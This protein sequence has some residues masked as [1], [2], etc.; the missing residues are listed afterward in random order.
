MIELRERKEEE[1]GMNILVVEDD[2][3]IREGIVEF[4]S[5]EGYQVLEAADGEEGLAMFQKN[6]VHLILLDIMLPKMDGIQVLQEIRRFSKIPVLMLTAMTDE[7]TQVK[8][9]DELADDYMCKPFSLILLKK[10]VEALLRRNY[11]ESKIFTYGDA[12]VDFTGFTATYQGEDAL[13]KPKEIKLLEVLTA[14]KGQVMTREQ[15]LNSIWGE[16]EAPFD[17][18]IDVYVKN[19]R[20][21]L[22]LDCIITVKGVGYKIEL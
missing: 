18:V 12:V 21:K 13:V 9:F 2:A 4:L 16:E 19:L 8:S 17:R 6:P 11:A 10:R 7:E 20:K 15:I 22:K 3:V 14:N 1:K 5:E